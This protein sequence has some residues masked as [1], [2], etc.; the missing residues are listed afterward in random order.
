MQ[1]SFGLGAKNNVLRVLRKIE[2]FM[3]KFLYPNITGE[4]HLRDGYAHMSKEE[5]GAFLFF[6]EASQWANVGS[7]NATQKFHLTFDANRSSSYYKEDSVVQ[8]KSIRL[9]FIVRI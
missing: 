7:V 1:K 4:A 5:I 3:L 2:G 8:V 6:K 9:L